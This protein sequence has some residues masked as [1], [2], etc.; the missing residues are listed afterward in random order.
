MEDARSIN[1]HLKGRSMWPLLVE[2]DCLTFKI[3]SIPNTK[4]GF[5]YL[6]KSPES[7]ELFV[8]RYIESFKAFKGDNNPFFDEKNC[9]VLGE[10]DFIGSKGHI[11]SDFLRSATSFFSSFYS[12]RYPKILR[13]ISKAFLIALNFLS[14]KYCILNG[15]PMNP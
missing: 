4:N 8:H 5:I 15:P 3:Q 10:L 14:R 12:M 1:I 11:S 13:V 6:C 9:H 7:S 2:G